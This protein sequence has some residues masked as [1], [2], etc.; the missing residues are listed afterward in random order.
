M[1]VEAIQ[2]G[3]AAATSTVTGLRGYP[4][5]PGSI[6]PPVAAPYE[7]ELTYHQAFGGLSSAMFTVGVFASLGDTDAGRK[8]LVGYL[9]PSGTGSVPAAIEADKTLGGACKTLVVRRARGA[10]RLYEI[11]GTNYLGALLDV[12]VWA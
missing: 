5:L 2:Q 6:N 10:Y 12:E 4:N 3:L 1:D 11:G 8:A 9:A 7:F